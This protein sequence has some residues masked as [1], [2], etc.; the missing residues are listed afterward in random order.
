MEEIKEI[1]EQYEMIIINLSQDEKLKEN[2]KKY[3]QCKKLLSEPVIERMVKV[4]NYQSTFIKMLNYL[5][6]FDDE[7]VFDTFKYI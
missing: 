6:D 2:L 7:I 4:K 1:L 3:D 5:F